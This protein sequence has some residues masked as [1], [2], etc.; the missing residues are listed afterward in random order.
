MKKPSR[1]EILRRAQWAGI[2][3]GTVFAAAFILLA[4][5][6]RL[7]DTQVYRMGGEVLLD[8]GDLYSAHDPETGLPFTYTPFAAMLFTPFSL[9]PSQLSQGLWTAALLVSLYFFCAIC[10][11]A[12]LGPVATRRVLA[13]G[14]LAGFALLL[15]PIRTNFD[16]GQINIFLALLIMADLFGR[17]RLVPRGVLIGVAAGIKLTPLIF[18]PFLFLT[19]RRRSAAW[20]AAAFAATAAAGFLAAP[21]SSATYWRHVF[22][23]AEH[24]G[25][26][27]YVGNQSLLGVLARL[28]DGADAARPVFL[29]LAVLLL[30]AGLAVSVLLFRRG[31]ALLGAL[32][33]ALTALLV[34]PISWSH[35]WVWIVPLLLCLSLQPNRPSWGRGCAAAGFVLFAL[36]PI[37]WVPR[38]GNAE[39][40]HHGWQLA[41]ANCYF[42][43]ALVL[44]ALLAACLLDRPARRDRPWR[45]E[46]ATAATGAGR[47]TPRQEPRQE[48]HPGRLPVPRAADLPEPWTSTPTRRSGS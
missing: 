13:F 48:P 43:A 44:L 21:G 31:L 22:L 30:A 41:A 39:F 46:A 6:G 29:P 37:W 4:L 7:T 27:P 10:H 14:S 42:A 12:V 47:S 5:T 16:L 34:S 45:A 32:A 15:E 20:A 24:V 38:T 33:C 28:M 19:G 35:H 36:G 23:D 2:L 9:L 11:E 40:L 25:G 18:I 17:R 1:E 26:I 3:T 8:G